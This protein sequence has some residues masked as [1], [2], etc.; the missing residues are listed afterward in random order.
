MKRQW[1]IWAVFAVCVAVAAAAM[2]WISKTVLRLDRAEADARRQALVE[3]A[4]RSAL[5]RMDFQIAPVI[6]QE[7]ARP[8]FTYDPFFPAHRAYAGVSPEQRSGEFL[9]SPIIAPPSDLLLLHFQ[10]SPTGQLTSPQA[11]TDRNTRLLAEAQY[12]SH[13]N[14]VRAQMRLAELRTILKRDALVALLPEAKPLREEPIAASS[15]VPAQNGNSDNNAYPN[16]NGLAGA[17]NQRYNRGAGLNS[18]GG[19]QGSYA[20][21]GYILNNDQPQQSQPPQQA[22]MQQQGDTDLQQ[23]KQA[24][25]GQQEFQARASSVQYSQDLLW[26]S[27][28]YLAPSGAVSE[29]YMKPIW[30]GSALVLARRVNVSGQDIIQGVWFDWPA[31]QQNLLGNVSDLLPGA[32][33]EPVA[34]PAGQPQPRML[35]AL[36]VRLVPGPVAAGADEPASPIR[37]TLVIAWASALLGAAAIALLL[38]GVIALSERR[39]SFVSAVTH[40]LRTPLTTLRMYT[41]MLS[42]GMVADDAQRGCYLTTLRNEANRLGHLVE[43]VLG[44]S[45][46]E[47]R[48]SGGRVET[49]PLGDLLGGMSQRLVE[50]AAQNGKTL[51]LT[52]P[53]DLAAARVAAD[54]V[55][56]EQI[57][58]NLVDNACKYAKPAAD[59]T[60]RLSA[61]RDGDLLA[62]AVADHGPGLSKKAAR[63]LFRPFSKSAH[64]AAHSAP[65][66]GLG[67]ALSRRLARNM[68]GDLT[69]ANAEGGG[70]TFVL[71]LAVVGEG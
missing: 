31:V 29:G 69:L 54:V 18:S 58:F 8:Y 34:N 16:Y 36:P 46:L 30:V 52:V 3:E 61:T 59:A 41:E 60:V 17:K 19:G 70:A 4:V 9:P 49:L 57:L 15:V 55:A 68:G 63:K 2:G 42:D 20:N 5:W 28:R 47:R 6:A 71:T 26:G 40:E 65:G 37:L 12:T 53:P 48:R 21:G 22:A 62:L 56:T 50:H 24:L 39:A 23:S 32:S 27:N 14:V 64:E 44:Y 13:D 43:N 25:R 10:V 45:R 67:L 35:A 33:L 66:L 7:N 38:R 11:P 1:I 51:A